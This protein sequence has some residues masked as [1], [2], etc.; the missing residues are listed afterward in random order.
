MLSMPQPTTDPAVP[1]APIL[2]VD[3]DA[4]IVR[5]VRTY[6]ERD[7]FKT[8]TLPM[9]YDPAEDGAGLERAMEE[10]CR[11]ASDAVNAGYTILILS[12][13]GVDAGRALVLAFDAAWAQAAGD[14]L[15]VATAAASAVQARRMVMDMC[16]L[17]RSK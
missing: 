9:L 3:D 8:I 10:L 13:R 11:R 1:T 16:F 7:G 2:V 14:M 17:I 12:D 6:L 4:K 5:L 15:P